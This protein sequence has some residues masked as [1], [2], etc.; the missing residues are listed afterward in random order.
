MLIICIIIQSHINCVYKHNKRVCPLSAHSPFVTVLI[1]RPIGY[2]QY[3]DS[4][5]TLGTG[6]AAFVVLDGVVLT[7]VAVVVVVVVVVVLVGLYLDFFF[8]FLFVVS[9]AA[10]V[11]GFFVVVSV[12]GIT[13]NNIEKHLG[14]LFKV[15][16]KSQNIT[17]RKD[18]W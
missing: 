15:A 9:T 13:V 17:L 11:V 18:G 1:N 2:E 8:F 16:K 4:F 7:G 14:C 12:D 3:G 5:L 6:F 10:V